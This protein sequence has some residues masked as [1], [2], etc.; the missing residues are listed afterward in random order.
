MDKAKNILTSVVGFALVTTCRLVKEAHTDARLK[1]R[2]KEQG[3][4]EMGFRSGVECRGLM[5]APSCEILLEKTKEN[6]T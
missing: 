3:I 2:L 6:I 5:S 4:Y 1:E